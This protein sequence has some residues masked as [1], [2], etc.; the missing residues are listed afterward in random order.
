MLRKC[1]EW[2]TNPL[3]SIYIYSKRLKTCKNVFSV[4]KDKQ[5]PSTLLLTEILTVLSQS[6]KKHDKGSISVCGPAPNNK[7]KKGRP[8]W[9][10][11]FDLY[12]GKV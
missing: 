5:D 4:P 9:E 6:I 2:H 1:V 7:V 10:L 11:T 8:G 12:L 3:S